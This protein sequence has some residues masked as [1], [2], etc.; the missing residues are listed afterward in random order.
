MKPRTSFNPKRRII[1]ARPS[2]ENS[3]RWEE[4]VRYGGNPEHKKNPGDFDLSPPSNPRQGKTLC[5]NAEMVRRDEVLRL[6]REGIRRGMLSEQMR[7]GWPQN[8]W[9]VAPNGMPLEAQLEN[10]VNGTY[11]GYPLQDVDPLSAI[12][13]KAWESGNGE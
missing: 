6:I 11:H 12:I 2:P 9:A 13:K 4:N 1:R 10:P 7:N 3:E 5:D 8:I